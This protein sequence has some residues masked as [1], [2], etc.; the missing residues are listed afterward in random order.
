MSE[1]SI[2]AS[3]CP[4][5]FASLRLRAGASGESA[6][7]FRTTLLIA[8]S[9][10]SRMSSQLPRRKRRRGIA[11]QLRVPIR[12]GTGIDDARRSLLQGFEKTRVVDVLPD[13]LHVRM[14]G[15]RHRVGHE[16][17]RIGQGFF[18]GFKPDDSPK[19]WFYF[20]GLG[21]KGVW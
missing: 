19:D 1:K 14:R 7:V 12:P 20:G 21:G 6:N 3:G 13:Y 11:A 2:C 17:H 16:T 15:A 4:A 5:S 8:D 9:H 10:R 18:G